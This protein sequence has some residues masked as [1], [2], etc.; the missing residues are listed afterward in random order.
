MT[1]LVTGSFTATGVSSPLVS[2]R[3]DL[4]F[5]SFNLSIFGTFSATVQLQRSF[6]GGVT[7][8]PRTVAGSA[9]YS[10]TAPCSEIIPEQEVG[11]LYRLDC[12][13]YTSGTVNYRISQ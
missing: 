4:I 8:L 12:S 9:A 5:N 10:Y 1:A 11:V 2:P 13:S 6:D 7:W 3:A